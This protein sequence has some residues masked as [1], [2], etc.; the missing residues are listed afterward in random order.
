MGNTLDFPLPVVESGQKYAPASLAQEILNLRLTPEGTLESVRGPLPLIPD[1]GSGYPYSGR[2]Y[3]VFHALLD[4]GMRDVTLVRSGDT[5]YQ[6]TGWTRSVESLQ[7]GLSS[8]P[9]ARWPDQ[10][11]EV[12]GKIVWNNGVN[13]PLVYDGYVLLPLGFD[14]TP[15]APSAAGPNDTGHP[16]FRNRGG[17]SHPGHIGTVGDFF[18]QGQ[19]ALLPYAREYYVQYEDYFGNRS[20]LSPASNAVTLR[21]ELTQDLFWHDYTNYPNGTPA[22]LGLLTVNTSDLTK[23]FLVEGIPSG[24][25]GTVARLLYA[26]PDLNKNPRQPRLLV[27]I[28]DNIS[29]VYPD[30]TPDGALGAPAEDYINVPRFTAMCA[31]NGRLVVL[32]GRNVRISEPGFIGSF[33]RNAVASLDS[34]GAEPSGVF[35]FGGKLYA[36]TTRTL[37]SV[38]ETEL[39]W[40]ARPVSHGTG[41]VGPNAV[42]S[43]PFGVCVGLDANGFWSL[44]LNGTITPISEEEYPLF[45]RLKAGYLSHA[46]VRWS[47]KDRELLCALPKAGPNYGNTLIM[48]WDGR[49]W[50]RREYGIAFEYLCVTKDWR[51]DVY[52]AGQIVGST[53][54]VFNLSAEAQT[55]TPPTRTSRFRSQWLRVDP[56]GRRRCTVRTIFIGIVE[57]SSNNLTVTVWQNGS[58]DTT[59]VS[60]NVEACNPATTDLLNTLVLGTGKARTPRLTWKK[61]DVRVRSCESFSFDVSA[62]YPTPLHIAAFAFDAGLEEGSGRDGSRQ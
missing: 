42:D 44:D 24:P 55:Y 46:C 50:R 26:T 4:A 61:V 47:P 30:N 48:A 57:S 23:Q 11:V 7:T 9:N 19:G 38:E 56:T 5:L 58:R 20:A 35:S 45:K 6:Q 12:A 15:G 17:Y 18:S 40:Q 59:V 53:Y 16:V 41:L 49:G 29:N 32:E 21:Q 60:K 10:F 36:A 2:M 27:R 8:D 22:E 31:H 3:G 33:K 25:A 1:Y 34:D 28:P 14:R 37:F 62:A 52:G 43:T 51:Q 39:G 54:N 13:T